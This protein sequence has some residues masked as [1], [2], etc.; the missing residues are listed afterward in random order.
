RGEEAIAASRFRRSRQRSHRNDGICAALAPRTNGMEALMR[1]YLAL[2][3]VG[4]CALTGA[5]LYSQA[6]KADWYSP[7]IYR[8]TS[9]SWTHV[10]YDDGFCHY[11]SANNAWDNET[12]VNRWGDCARV[13]I[14]PN[15]EAMPIAPGP[16]VRY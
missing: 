13:A 15:G 12:Q 1:S 8:E 6:A 16:L 14:G 11:K 10:E 9:G 4:G 5:T 2:A 7:H 3:I